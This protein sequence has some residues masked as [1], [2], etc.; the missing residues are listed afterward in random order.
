MKKR[1]LSIMTVI[2]AVIFLCG[3]LSVMAYPSNEKVNKD[4]RNMSI[5]NAAGTIIPKPTA[6][7][8]ANRVVNGAGADIAVSYTGYDCNAEFPTLT[9]YVGDTLTFTDMSRGNNGDSIAEWDWQ[10][11]GAMGDHHNIYKNNIVNT[12]SFNLTEPG[13]TIFYLCVK[14][15]VKVKKGCCDPWSGNGNHQTVGRNKWF[16]KGAYWYFTAVRV[17]V[18]PIREAIV[19][20]RYWDAQNNRVFHEGTVNAGQIF[21]DADTVDTSVHITDWD[22]YAYSGWNVQLPDGTIQYSGNER[23]VG[24]TLA[25]WVPQKYLNVE[26]FPY[27]NTGVEIRYWDKEEN[28]LISTEN[29]MGGTVLREQETIIAATINTPPGYKT[30]GWNVQ[31]PDGTIQYEGTGNPTDITVNG[32]IP[33]KIL[34]VKCYPISDKKVTVNY[35]N[36]ETKKVINTE[37]IRAAEGDGTQTVNVSFKN[38]PGYVIE[39]WTLE[40]PDGKKEREGTE[41]PVEVILTERRPHK[42][43]N[44]N[45]F[46]IDDGDDIPDTPPGEVVVKPSGTCNGIIEWSETDSHQVRYRSNGKTKYRTCTHKFEYKTVLSADAVISPSTLKSGY[47]FE[48]EVKYSISTRLVSNK[49]CSSWGGGRSPASTVKNP[50]KATIY[51]PWEMSNRLGTQGKTISMEDGGRLKFI[52]PKSPVS[53]IGARKIY[54]PVTLAGTKEEPKSHSFEI[55]INGGGVGNTE[56][57]RKIDKSITVNGDMYEDDFSGAD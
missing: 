57:C 56:F 45:C 16:P 12:Q 4:Y 18:K 37:I 35:I 10:Y 39:D 8:S 55:Y 13:E 21:G 6:Q 34:N 51:L 41:E 26:F 3:T 17:V 29:L 19:N 5:Q 43:L 46:P 31:L 1:I 33:K 14:S 42:I 50:T 36:S 24:I 30:D 49:G 11:F 9:C 40:L 27:M 25:G 54:T 38:V 48:V 47:G 2:M 7:F 53:E 32:Y 22:G 20:V 28:K 23:D 15:D 44:I 52:L